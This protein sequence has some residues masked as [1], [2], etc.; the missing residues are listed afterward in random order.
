MKKQIND[1]RTKHTADVSKK[2]F[3]GFNLANNK[4]NRLKA[5]AVGKNEE[6]KF[7]VKR[8]QPNNAKVLTKAQTYEVPAKGGSLADQRKLFKAQTYTIETKDDRKRDSKS[9]VI[10]KLDVDCNK[11]L[12]SVSE[13][14]YINTVLDNQTREILD[15][16]LNEIEGT[17]HLEARSQPHVD[18]PTEIPQQ[19]QNSLKEVKTPNIRITTK[20]SNLKKDVM[21]KEHQSSPLSQNEIKEELFKDSGAKDGQSI[22]PDANLS[23]HLF[24]P[25]V[26]ESSDDSITEP[27]IQEELL[28]N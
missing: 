10:K 21:K 15:P 3:G 27:S 16:S 17:G 13:F 28:V 1:L 12:P 6:S 26:N 11:L 14:I 24:K 7:A 19:T 8:L 25:E 18:D 2:G 22:V 4:E 23:E 5:L 9:H 20:G